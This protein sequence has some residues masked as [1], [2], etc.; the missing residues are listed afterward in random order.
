MSGATDKIK[1]YIL[2]SRSR[3]TLPRSGLVQSDYT[4]KI[5]KN[6]RIFA[7]NRYGFSRRGADGKNQIGL[8]AGPEAGVLE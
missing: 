6:I 7:K 4:L 8:S 3:E 5:L 1:A 2:Q